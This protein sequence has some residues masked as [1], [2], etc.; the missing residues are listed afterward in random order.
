MPDVMAIG[1]DLFPAIDV[2]GGACVRLHKGDYAAKTEYSHHPAEVAAR[3]IAQ[4][5]RWLHV[6]DLDG[7]KSGSFVNTSAIMDVVRVA[8]AA[9]VQVQ[10]G[11]GIRT[12][13]DVL[14]LLDVG[15][16]R[17]IIGTSALQLDWME[18]A[19]ETFGGD[20]LVVGL[21]GRG[22]KMAVRGW[23]E[24]TDVNLLDVAKQLVQRGVRHAL[25]TDVERDGTLQGA[26][27]ALA[28][29][30]QDVGM[31]VLASGGIRNLDDVLASREAGL[32][33]AIVGRSIY[34]GTLDLR[35]AF[36]ALEG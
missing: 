6:V 27:L 14:R 17:C 3:W 28:R 30:I 31:Q 19:V 36:L 23:L 15:V 26:N 2:L 24:Q 7:A 33:G 29:E 34:D 4:G 1:F 10:V 22:G 35:T 13:D 32:A 9:G 21:D 11:G 25:V 8:E 18:R 20:R 12:H 5:A 16:T